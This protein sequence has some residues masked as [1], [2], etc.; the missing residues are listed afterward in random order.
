MAFLD[1]TGSTIRIDAVLTDEGRKRITQGTFKVTKFSLGDDEIDYS[2]YIKGEVVDAAEQPAII[3]TPI[4]EAF[5]NRT[6]NIYSGLVSY[7]NK[8]LLWLPILK[9]NDRAPT[10]AKQYTMPA[11]RAKPTVG[12]SYLSGTFFYMAANEETAEKIVDYFNS[13]VGEGNNYVLRDSETSDTKI[14]IE[15]GIDTGIP[16]DA[17]AKWQGSRSNQT[18]H[19]IENALV[20]NY[21]YVTTDPRFIR[22]LYS[23]NKES[24]FRTRPAGEPDVKLGPLLRTKYTTLAPPV[25]DKQNFISKGILNQVYYRGSATLYPC[26]DVSMFSGPRG[27]VTAFNFEIDPELTTTSLGERSYKYSTY[28]QINQYIT[29]TTDKYDIIDIPVTVEGVNSARSIN[30]HVRLVRYSGT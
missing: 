10:A 8:D 5:E 28:G 12:N 29:N 27:S 30:L 9:I 3:S 6:A 15:S 26:E 22:S 23:L 21:Y 17:G 14:I 19:L 25:K 4:F 24:Y 11:G 13:T 18:V 1:T 16:E 20:D 2:M 7:G